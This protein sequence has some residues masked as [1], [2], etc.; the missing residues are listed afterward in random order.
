MEYNQEIL[1]ECLAL[2]QPTHLYQTITLTKIKTPW[3]KLDHFAYCLILLNRVDTKDIATTS[4]H[5]PL[6]LTIN[7][8]SMIQNNLF[9]TKSELRGKIATKTRLP[10][11]V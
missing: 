3:I 2:N 6:F 10:T 11:N 8:L 5:K 4:I 9:T 1:D 7:I